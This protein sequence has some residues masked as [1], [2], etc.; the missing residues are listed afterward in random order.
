MLEQ[1]QTQASPPPLTQY[2]TTAAGYNAVQT[3]SS[4]PS[5]EPRP[6]PSLSSLP[7]PA[8]SPMIV[9]TAQ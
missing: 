8:T 9:A 3:Q 2:S 7:P 6:P 1:T 5:L 4:L